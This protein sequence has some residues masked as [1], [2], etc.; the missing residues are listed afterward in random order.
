MHLNVNSIKIGL[1][2]CK[3]PW[4]IIVVGC[5]TQ[6]NTIRYPGVAKFGIALEWGS[7]GRWFKSSHSDQEEVERLPLFVF[8]NADCRKTACVFRSLE[9]ADSSYFNIRPHGGRGGACAV[10]AAGSS[11]VTRTT[12][13]SLKDS[14]V[15][16][17]FKLE[18]L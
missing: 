4:Y 8:I 12:G 11:P 15:F 10:T 18:L 16:F 1:A 6:Q 2:F 3:N 5:E 7:R 14:P 17:L 13:E 9:P